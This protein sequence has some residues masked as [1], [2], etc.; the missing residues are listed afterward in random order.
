MEFSIRI[1]LM[2]VLIFI[3]ALLSIMLISGW[4]GQGS[5]GISTYTDWIGG[6]LSGN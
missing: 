1:L 3:V 5:E 4:M 2:A 6:I